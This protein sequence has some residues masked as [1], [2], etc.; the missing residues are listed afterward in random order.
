MPTPP[1]AQLRLLPFRAVRFTASEDLADL[2]CP[3]YD[4][5]DEE[6]RRELLARDPHNVVRIILPEADEDRNR[7]DNGADNG[8][9]RYAHA[10]ALFDDWLAEGVLAADD[11]PA[12]YV[13]QQSADGRVLQRGL[14]GAVVWQPLDAGV[15]VPHENVR[16]GPVQDR[17]ALMR[18]MLANPEPIFLLY[19]G[20]GPATDICEAV[21]GEPPI[22]IGRTPDGVMHEL[23]AVTDRARLA[24]I[25][26]DLATRTAMI[27]DG[28][29]RYTTYGYLRDELGG[30]DRAPGPWD[31][32]LTLLVDESAGAPD[33]RAIHR[34]V[35]GLAMPEAALRAAG[36][37]G[38][39][40]LPGADLSSAMREL[41][42]ATAPAYVISDGQA[43]TLL[44]D[45]DRDRLAAAKPDDRGEAW[46]RLDAS[47]ASVLLMDQL[48]GV[49]DTAGQ[50]EAEHEPAAALRL[51]THTDG[52][53]LLLNPAPL[54]GIVAVAE[55]GE[56]MPRKSTLF[57][58]K[59]C[60]GLVMRAFRF[61]G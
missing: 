12:L 3:P 14:L 44:F 8:G 46:W 32:G 25:D 33:I 13:Y 48:W 61:E 15:I 41:A 47:V 7:I 57:L 22:A 10:A 51:A 19:G 31:A 53:A 20:G 28:H 30:A 16:P 6:Q 21:C 42:A 9:D 18:A 56:A 1:P 58:P 23:W 38:V 45:P 37:F 17:L 40:P 27:A 60:S 50:V 54:A 43:F 29:H 26:D 4:V 39:R 5:I 49:S 24:A 34:V 11:E 55:A 52:T 2:V 35:P 59:P 36:A